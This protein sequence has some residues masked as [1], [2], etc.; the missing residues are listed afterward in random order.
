MASIKDVLTMVIPVKD[1]AEMVGM[2]EQNIRSLIKSGRIRVK[3]LKPYRIQIK[4]GLDDFISYL[5]EKNSDGAP[6]DDDKARREKL[7]ADADISIYKAKQEQ[8]KW[9]EMKGMLHRSED[10]Q[11]MTEDLIYTI[12]GAITALPG[13][14]AMDVAAEDDPNV[15]NNRIK[16]EVILIL[17]HLSEYEYS[18]TKYL[19]RMKERQGD[20]TEDE[21][22]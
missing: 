5:K 3:N 4:E 13:K 11:S 22:G 15:C 17:E 16:E 8:A 20:E 21:E 12:R 7:R 18:K 14:L 6:V 10:V 9:E 19:Q 2:S 1:F